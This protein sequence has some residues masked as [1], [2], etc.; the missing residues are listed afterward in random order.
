MMII[1]LKLEGLKRKGEA[2]GVSNPW[3]GRYKNPGMGKRHIQEVGRTSVL[4]PRRQRYTVKMNMQNQDERQ[5][6][7]GH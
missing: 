1:K 2:H 3:K 7:E 5:P 6:P 4:V